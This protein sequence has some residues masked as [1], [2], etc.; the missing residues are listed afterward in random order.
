MGDSIGSIDIPSS[1]FFWMLCP[2]KNRTLVTMDGRARFAELSFVGKSRIK[3]T[4]LI[5]FP[6][7]KIDRN[8]VTAPEADICVTKGGPFYIADIGTK[9]TKTFFAGL[10]WRW[11][12]GL[13]RILDMEKG[14]I[15][16]R[17]S[18]REYD[19]ITY[20]PYYNI[21][22]DPK[23]DKIL[24]KSPEI[25][26]ESI[27]F[28]C[29]LTP[30]LVLIRNQINKDMRE[31]V[32]YNWITQEIT[33]NE[34]TKKLTAFKENTFIEPDCNINIKK[35][36][37]FADLRI[38]GEII[39][40]KIKITWDENYEDVKVI[41]MDYLVPEGKWFYDFYFSPDGKW[42]TNFVG[43]YRGLYGELLDKRIFFHLD[44][45]YPNGI[46]MPIFAD[47]YYENPWEWGSFVEH[48]VHGMCYAEE[49]YKNDKLYLRLYK[50]D[51]VLAEIN[52]K[53]LEKANEV[54]H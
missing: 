18:S 53:L 43:G 31:T 37:L 26:G 44:D 27:W 50:M 24:Y 54:L 11:H 8:L 32:M 40:K 39:T 52:R 35:R 49:K 3:I 10:S 14:I 30:E 5:N 16:L 36:Y 9:K 20:K 6:R 15:V 2:W 29:S 1:G 23:N 22:Y 28:R 21:I 45:R 38:P 34:L 25:A 12:Q 19:N 46:S 51:D 7:E 13:P 48:P 47:D 42:A 4:P 33:M 41:P 17:Y